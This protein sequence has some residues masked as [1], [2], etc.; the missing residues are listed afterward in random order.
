MI[1]HVSPQYN[2]KIHTKE[3]IDWS[4]LYT[5]DQIWFPTRQKK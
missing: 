2:F 5:T 3:T 4:V 1:L